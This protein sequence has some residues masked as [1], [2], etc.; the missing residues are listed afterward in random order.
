MTAIC[1][2]Q[3]LEVTPET[4]KF[5]YGHRIERSIRIRSLNE[6]KLTLRRIQNGL[7]SLEINGMNKLP[8]SLDLKIEYMD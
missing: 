5:I 6:K 3:E 1:S 2:K 8:D 7:K 4:A